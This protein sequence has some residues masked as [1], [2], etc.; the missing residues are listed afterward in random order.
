MRPAPSCPGT[1]RRGAGRAGREE[2]LGGASPALGEKP[3]QAELRPGTGRL[4]LVGGNQGT[5]S[6]RAPSPLSRGVMASPGYGCLPW[7]TPLQPPLRAEASFPVEVL[8]QQM[9]GPGN[10]R[11]TGPGRSQAGKDRA[12]WE[13]RLSAPRVADRV[14]GGVGVLSWPGGASRTRLRPHLPIP[15]PT[16]ACKPCSPPYPRLGL[17]SVLLVGCL[18]HSPSG[19]PSSSDPRLRPR[20]TRP[21]PPLSQR[22]VQC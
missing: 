10:G 11:G 3:G 4:H 1:R 21:A 9:E 7:H 5:S 20:R 22:R 14:Q 15:P 2:V 8:S 19:A 16:G 13:Q 17:T 18:K 6:L 12:G